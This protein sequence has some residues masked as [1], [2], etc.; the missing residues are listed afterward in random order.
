[1]VP[2]ARV[3]QAVALRAADVLVLQEMLPAH[4][5]AAHQVAAI[6][7]LHRRLRKVSVRLAWRLGSRYLK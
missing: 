5:S 3:A 7:L 2:E 6:R 4:L 1:M